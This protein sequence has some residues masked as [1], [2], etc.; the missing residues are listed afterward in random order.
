ML[1]VCNSVVRRDDD[2]RRIDRFADAAG[3]AG[4]AGAAA[5]L[6]AEQDFAAS[7]ERVTAPQHLL[8]LREAA[9]AH[10]R[11]VSAGAPDMLLLSAMLES[12]AG[13][14][15]S[16]GPANLETATALSALKLAGTAAPERLKTCRDCGWLYFDRS[17]N[18]SRAWCDMA[19]CGNRAK[20]R[21]H[22]RA[23]KQDV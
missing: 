22:Y 2:A 14:L 11:A 7:I 20:A 21:R 23:R 8:A 3:M 15:K 1:D 6:C 13:A 10:F 17:K 19:V 4:F 18:R 9:D 16:G 12:A 5:S